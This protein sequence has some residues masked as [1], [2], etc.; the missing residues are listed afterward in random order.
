MI[1]VLS[2]NLTKS[3]LILIALNSITA[4]Y[5]FRSLRTI[6]GAVKSL[7]SLFSNPGGL[8]T[9]KLIW[10]FILIVL[11]LISMIF[12]RYP[13]STTFRF[14]LSLALSLW[15]SRMLILF[16]K[17]MFI[18]SVLPLNSPWYLVSFLRLVEVIRIFMRPFTLCFRLLAN[19]RAG[20]IL[21]SLITKIKIVWVLGTLFGLLELMVCVV[22]A[23][24]FIMLVSVYIEE[25]LSH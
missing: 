13:A 2:N 3:V 9:F 11:N 21:L 1:I 18:S 19:I 24:V 6:A 25:S 15:L 23:F 22:Q 12:Y 20:H 8:I 17:P 14:N 5:L 16:R 10:F 7:R 4:F